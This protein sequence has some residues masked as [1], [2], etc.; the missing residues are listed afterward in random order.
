MYLTF[1][2]VHICEIIQFFFSFLYVAY[3]T[4]HNVFQVHCKWQDL[5]LFE[6]WIIFHHICH[7]FF[8]HQQTLRAFPYLDCYKECCGDCGWDVR[9]SPW[10]VGSL[11][12]GRYSEVLLLPLAGLALG[13]EKP[14]YCFL[15][16]Y[17]HV[18]PHW[19]CTEISLLH[20]LSNNCYLLLLFF[21]SSMAPITYKPTF[22]KFTV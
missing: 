3:L 4:L 17:I 5:F 6:D 1:G 19:Q 12:L 18:H 2:V 10:G 13:S 11:H 9:M 16:N 21:G 20:I 14:P 8:I 22:M 15:S 7:S